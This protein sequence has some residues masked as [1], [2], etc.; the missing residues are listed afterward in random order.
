[1]IA[2][3]ALV[4]CATPAAEAASCPLP[5]EGQQVLGAEELAFCTLMRTDFAM[6]SYGEQGFSLDGPVP[7]TG[8][9]ASS[10][11]PLPWSRRGTGSPAAGE[12]RGG[13]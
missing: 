6:Q 9:N 7:T 5:G 3:L 10:G 13:R 4:A 8:M 11:T 2:S 1:M 12:R